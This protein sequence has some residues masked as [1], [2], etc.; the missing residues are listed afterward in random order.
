MPQL[1]PT[2]WFFVGST[3]MFVFIVLFVAWASRANRRAE[4]AGDN[5]FYAVFSSIMA[6]PLC[7]ALWVWSLS[8]WD[9]WF[10]AAMSVNVLTCVYI[11]SMNW[12]NYSVFRRMAL[13]EHHE[14]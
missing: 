3:F 5:L 2:Q 7:G 13:E 6:V 12:Y 8:V 9:M 14:S 1:S 11:T 10:W 4:R